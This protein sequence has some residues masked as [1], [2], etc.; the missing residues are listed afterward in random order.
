ML[1]HKVR[2][3]DAFCPYRTRQKHNNHGA[4]RITI[5]YPFHPLYGQSVH[6]QRRAK[7]PKG[8]YIFCEF[9]DG[10]IGGFPSW[11]A[12]PAES[13]NITVGTPLTSAEALAELRTLLDS[14][15]SSAQHA[16]LREMRRE[17]TNDTEENLRDGPDESTVL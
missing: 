8:E 15:H 16:S 7:F 13:L 11:I 6:V 14:L 5:H 12:D 1:P 17:S 4:E 2:S 9:A 3:R 10:T